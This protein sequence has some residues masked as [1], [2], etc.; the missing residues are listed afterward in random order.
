VLQTF[1]WFPHKH[2]SKLS[3]VTPAF[4]AISNYTFYYWA[5]YI[6]FFLCF[7]EQAPIRLWS[8]VFRDVSSARSFE[9][10]Q[11]LH[12]WGHRDQK[13]F[14]CCSSETLANT[15]PMVHSHI[16]E[17][18]YPQQNHCENFR[19]CTEISMN[20]TYDSWKS[21]HLRMC[22]PSPFEHVQHP[23]CHNKTSKYVD[24]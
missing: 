19:S 22:V 18:L 7:W 14:I 15:Q 23:L 12:L 8:Q 13:E 4:N 21:G 1:T 9:G 10:L 5:F 11:C 2:N 17:D 3:T 16:P 24:E 6:S 20:A